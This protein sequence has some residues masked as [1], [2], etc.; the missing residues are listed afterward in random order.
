[1][2]S[3]LQS[4]SRTFQLFVWLYLIFL[5][6]QLVSSRVICEDGGFFQINSFFSSVASC[7]FNNA[8]MAA[9]MAARFA[10]FSLM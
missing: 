7:A 8:A 10:S 3:S 9:S 6:V 4:H 1:M 5:Q 2:V